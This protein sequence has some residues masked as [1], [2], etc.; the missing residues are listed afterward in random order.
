[1]GAGAKVGCSIYFCLRELRGGL[2]KEK[3]KFKLIR[4]RRRKEENSKTEE[5]NDCAFGK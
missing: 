2:S 5:K 1:M 4:G 3:V